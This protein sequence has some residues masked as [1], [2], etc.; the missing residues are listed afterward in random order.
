ML[1]GL[2]LVGDPIGPLQAPADWQEG[3]ALRFQGILAG[4]EPFTSEAHGPKLDWLLNYQV[5]SMCFKFI[6]LGAYLIYLH[7]FTNTWF[8]LHADSE[9]WVSR[10]PND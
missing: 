2:P 3:M 6:Y 1:L 9:V 4:A 5:R 10:D 8:L 7:G